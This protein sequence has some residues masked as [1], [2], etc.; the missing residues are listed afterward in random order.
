[1]FLISTGIFCRTSHV[2]EGVMF[3]QKSD[4]CSSVSKN[5]YTGMSGAQQSVLS[6]YVYSLR[7]NGAGFASCKGA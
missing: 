7:T 3:C 5:N 2:V 4:C 1:M 6:V